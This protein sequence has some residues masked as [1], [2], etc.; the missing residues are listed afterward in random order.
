MEISIKTFILYGAVVLT[1]LSAGLFYAWSI[2]VIPGTQKVVDSTYLET[3][4]SINRAILNPAFYVVFFGSII[5]LSIGS[6]YEFNTHKTIFWLMLSSSIFYLMGTVGVTAMGNVPLNNQLEVLNLGE[7]ASSKISAF[8]AFYE[9]NWNRLHLIRTVFAVAS[10]LL[11][12]LAVFMHVKIN[13]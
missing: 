7:M 6:I 4:Q 2:S 1:G 5:F 8:R 9:T 10:F 13:P 3:M 12:V 11:S